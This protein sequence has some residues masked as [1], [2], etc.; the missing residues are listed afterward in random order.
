MENRGIWPD[1]IGQ[2]LSDHIIVELDALR[3]HWGALATLWQNAVPGEREPVQY[4]QHRQ[5]TV[6]E[7]QQYKGMLLMLSAKECFIVQAVRVLGNSVYTQLL[8]G[9]C[10]DA[11]NCCLH[12]S[13]ANTSAILVTMYAAH[14]TECASGQ[15]TG[16]LCCPVCQFCCCCVDILSTQ[17]RQSLALHG[18]CHCSAVQCT[19]RPSAWEQPGSAAEHCRNVCPAPCFSCTSPGLA[20]H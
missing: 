19:A 13:Q 6:H 5:Y 10:M 4:R 14:F 12:C 2:H 8:W 9:L 17:R 16:D 15:A 7:G 3:V 20:V 18:G 11:N 1:A